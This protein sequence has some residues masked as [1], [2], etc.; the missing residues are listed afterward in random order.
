MP[1]DI[2]RV[3][4]VDDWHPSLDPVV[5]IP[6]MEHLPTKNLEDWIGG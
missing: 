1:K 5:S 4:I 2:I 3:V 6:N